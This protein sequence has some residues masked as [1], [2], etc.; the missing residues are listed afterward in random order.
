MLQWI[1][2]F[3]KFAGGTV[4]W[5]EE[6]WGRCA[7]DG[8]P[9]AAP[10][11]GVVSRP[12]QILLDDHTP[13]WP[14]QRSLWISNATHYFVNKLNIS[15]LFIKQYFYG[16]LQRIK[17]KQQKKNQCFF[18]KHIHT[19]KFLSLLAIEFS[20]D[21]FPNKAQPYLPI[22]GSILTNVFG[23]PSQSYSLQTNTI[24]IAIAQS[25]YCKT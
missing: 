1:L 9:G 16:M 11:V 13:A 17:G 6:G 23:S 8:A 14:M 25:F 15:C 24:Y 19:W 4:R 12:W 18:I 20:S 7:R 5:G 10:R 3:I 21:I 2:K 22:F